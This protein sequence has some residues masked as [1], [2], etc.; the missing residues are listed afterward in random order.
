MN[1]DRRWEAG[2]S[3]VV[4]VGSVLTLTAVVDHLLIRIIVAMYRDAP[5]PG[6]AQSGNNNPYQT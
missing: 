6:S 2:S 4:G 5:T 1:R 3:A